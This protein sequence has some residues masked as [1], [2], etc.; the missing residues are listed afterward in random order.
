[1]TGQSRLHPA[2]S[3]LGRPAQVEPEL[4]ADLV[5]LVLVAA[6]ARYL[7]DRGDDLGRIRAHGEIMPWI[8]GRKIT[9]P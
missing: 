3:E 4:A 8:H 2:S 9:R 1:M 6:A 5:E 7:D